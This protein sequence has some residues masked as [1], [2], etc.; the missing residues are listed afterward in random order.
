VCGLEHLE[1]GAHSS[2]NRLA[3]TLQ[4]GLG[5]TDDGVIKFLVLLAHDDSG[6]DGLGVVRRRGELEDLPDDLDDTVVRYDGSVLEWVYGAAV[7]GSLEELVGG[8]LAGHVCGCRELLRGCLVGGVV[9]WRTER[10]RRVSR[11]SVEILLGD[12]QRAL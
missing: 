9:E 2:P 4:N 5:R 7:L 11:C 8:N 10:L 12:D 1:P 6:A 3:S